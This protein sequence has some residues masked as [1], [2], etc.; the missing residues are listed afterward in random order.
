MTDIQNTLKELLPRMR[1]ADPTFR[2]HG[3]ERH[4][5]QLGPTLTERE[6]QA[7]EQRHQVAL[8]DDYRF[9]LKEIGN[10]G[11]QRSSAPALAI[12]AGAGP[13]CGIQ[14]LEE[15]VLDC[16]LS[17]PFPLTQSTEGQ[18]VEGWDR[19]GY[20]EA[21]PGV[22]EICYQGSA[23]FSYLVI[24]GPTYGRIWDLQWHFYPTGL[25]FEAWY[26]GWIDMLIERALPVLSNERVVEQVDIGMTKSQIIGICGGNWQQEPFGD[27]HS[28]LSFKHLATQFELDNNESLVRIIPHT[29]Y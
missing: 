2:V 7:F 28:F 29:I 21:Y 23:N 9:F 13:Y 10:G 6:L 19:W 11:P 3:S 5:Y 24:H 22:L 8:P 15:A 18:P 14:P 16:D 12:N 26:C 27:R 1:T 17:K 20:E 25:T 4:K